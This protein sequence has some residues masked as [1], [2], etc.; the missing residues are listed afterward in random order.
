[1]D[2]SNKSNQKEKTLFSFFNCFNI[3]KGDRKSRWVGHSYLKELNINDFFERKH[4]F[5]DME[6]ELTEAQKNPNTDKLV[7]AEEANFDETVT[8]EAKASNNMEIDL[9]K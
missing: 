7:V 6:S 2:Q 4:I 9:K 1:M 5:E 8:A 3:H